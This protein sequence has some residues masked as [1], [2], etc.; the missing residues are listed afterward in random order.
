MIRHHPARVGGS[1]PA[2]IR[3]ILIAAAGALAVT[4]V[5]T[6]TACGGSSNKGTGAVSTRPAT[7]LPG[8]AGPTTAATT[9]ATAPTATSAPI[10]TV[11]P[12][13][14]GSLPDDVSA[15]ALR[16]IIASAAAKVNDATWVTYFGGGEAKQTLHSKTRSGNELYS[17]FVVAGQ[18]SYSPPLNPGDRVDY[19]SVGHVRYWRVNDGA[20]KND[21]DE[22][23]D[24]SS[25]PDAFPSWYPLISVPVGVPVSSTLSGPAD[26]W[27]SP[28]GGS[29][30]YTLTAT[31]MSAERAA[32]TSVGRCWDLTINYELSETSPPPPN[33]T[34]WPITQRYVLNVCE[35][36]FLVT[37]FTTVLYDGRQ[38]IE[39]QYQ[40]NTGVPLVTPDKV[41]EV[42]CPPYTA[43]SQD[44][45]NC[46]FGG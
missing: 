30:T 27:K 18:N 25:Q 42:R 8:S 22:P 33:A 12:N 44:R 31:D 23:L 4:A 45:V 37:K 29:L 38:L 14:P 24:P 5:L 32:P 19:L 39:D 10:A 41:T 28:A 9:V 36:D 1:N 16:Q 40:Y 6:L 43:V 35:P 3:R 13:V 15:E 46:W 34:A 26:S 11:A 7:T 21:P 20:W 17:F 2:I